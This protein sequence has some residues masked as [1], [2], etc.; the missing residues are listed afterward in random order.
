MTPATT[1]SSPS[2]QRHVGF[3]RR[4]QA[5]RQLDGDSPP[6]KKYRMLSEIMAR[7]PYAVVERE[8][9]SDLLCDQCGSGELPEELLLCDKC[10]KGFHMKCVRPIV[11]RI[12]IGSWLCPNCQGG[13]RVRPFSQKKIIDFFGI[14]RSSD[15]AN[16]KRSSQD[17]KKRKKCSRP[18]VLHKKKRRLL[19]FVPT[20]DL[21][22]R[23]KQ[24]G[25]LASAL[26]ALNMEFSDHLTYLPGMAP[27]CA[28]QALLENG[29]MQT[30]SKEDMETL[31][32]CIALSKRGEFPPFMVVYDSREGYTVEADDLIKDMTIIAEYTGDVDYLDTRER[33]DC[34]SM[35]T[36]LLG[37][38]SSQS[39]VI[40]ADKRGNIARFISGINNH[41]QEGR[42]KQNCKCVRY[43]VNGE[44]R[45]F[46]VAIRDISKGERLY[47]DYN[48]HE[49]QYPTHH[50]V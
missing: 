43:N 47:Y 13:K 5:P 41:T 6:V 39:L 10:D 36:L 11:V 26:T 44:C 45:V 40:C 31:E 50:F 48:G 21:N 17:A 12:P 49:Y 9:Y 25:S 42:K 7:A 4:T 29:G 3:S 22:R 38:E 24:M 23:L 1:N 33:D 34:D 14:R 27:R 30:L 19:P 35:M 18:L 46:L 8:T 2:A 37:A 28:N 16:D 15:D 32:Q 20:K